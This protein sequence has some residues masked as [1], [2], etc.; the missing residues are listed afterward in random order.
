MFE[1]VSLS[2][3]H[4]PD[5]PEE[6]KRIV[7]RGGRV[8]TYLDEN[9]KPMGPYRVWLG[10]QNIPGLAMARS[11]GDIVASTV[12]VISHPEIR[13]FELASAR[14][15]IFIASDGVWEFLDNE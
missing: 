14:N 4:K 12:G 1:S 3:D 2:R 6:R 13:S 9:L 7:S 11:F 10:E 15:F 5:D 8:E